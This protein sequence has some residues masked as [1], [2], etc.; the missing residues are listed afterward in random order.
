MEGRAIA[1]PN[2]SG[3]WSPFGWAGGLQWR[4]GQLPGRTA[5]GHRWSI[6]R[7]TLQWRAG[8]LPG[9]TPNSRRRASPS[10]TAFNG[11]PGNCPAERWHGG[12]HAGMAS[13]F[14]GGPGNCPAEPSLRRRRME[15]GVRPSMEGR[16]IARP[17]ADGRLPI[18]R[19]PRAGLQWRAGQLPGRTERGAPSMEGRQLPGRRSTRPWNALQWRAGQLPGR[20]CPCRAAAVDQ[21]DF[22]SMEGRAIARPNIPRAGNIPAAPSA[23]NGGPGNCPAEPQAR[24]VAVGAGKIPS[25]EGRAIA[26]PNCGSRRPIR[27]RSAPFNGG[28]GNCPA[29]PCRRTSSRPPSIPFN[30]GPGNCP[31]EPLTGPFLPPSWVLTFNGGPGNC[32]AEPLAHVLVVVVV[33]PSM[34]GRAIARP[35]QDDRRRARGRLRPSMEGRAI[36]RPNRKPADSASRSRPGLQWRAGQ[37][38]GRTCN[39]Y[40]DHPTTIGPSM[41][42]RAIARPNRT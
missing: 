24:G 32:P 29:E 6:C 21:V 23:F 40:Y 13:S 2:A 28:P 4:A 14:N 26:R 8:Q 27:R 7:S 17:N 12:R 18:P 10:W 42:G 19:V 5:V 41:E 1:R 9:R 30:G 37:L 33:V 35:N 22:P 38:P 34:E 16:A 31:A 11:G 39:R 36:A 20:T 15:V 3:A 25:M